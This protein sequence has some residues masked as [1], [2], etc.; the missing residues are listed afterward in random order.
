MPDPDPPEEQV[1]RLLADA[2]HDEP[3]PAD[4]A[5]R[6]DR[7]LADLQ[8]ESRRTPD[9][10]DL[11]SRRRRRIARNMLIAAAAVV[12]V[13]V[14]ISRVDLAG[15]AGG[16]GSSD[17][18]ASA[19]ESAARD[20]ARGDAAELNS[21]AKGRPLVLS[22][23]DFDRQARS[24]SLHPRLASLADLSQADGYSA[25][26]GAGQGALAA[27]AWCIDPSWGD[28]EMIPVRYDGQ[29]GVL[30]LRNPVGDTQDVDLYLCGDSAPTRSTTVPVG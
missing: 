16:G 26:M 2:R 10:M 13:G 18:A 27:R 21:L 6:L 11:A 3:M 23:E 28:G 30:V 22:P 29:R 17:S 12:V 9:P 24:L 4:V 15:D 25:D 19:P 14:G 1:R 8:G 5:E 20:E 7:V